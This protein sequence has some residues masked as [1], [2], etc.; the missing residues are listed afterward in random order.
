MAEYLVTT[1]TDNNIPR[2]VVIGDVDQYAEH[3]HKHKRVTYFPGGAYPSKS[4]MRVAKY[5]NIA[6][7]VVNTNRMFQ[8]IK[9]L[10]DQPFNTFD[11]NMSYIDLEAQYPELFI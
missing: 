5:T 1:T 6:V 9:M 7:I 2:I 11:A 8:V 4:G 10:N 3:L